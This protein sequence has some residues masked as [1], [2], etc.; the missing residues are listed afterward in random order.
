MDLFT[1]LDRYWMSLLD[2]AERCGATP[3]GDTSET[4]SEEVSGQPTRQSISLAD[5][6]ALGRAV[7]AWVQ[8]R[9][10]RD[11]EDAEDPEPAIV[12][13]ERAIARRTNRSRANTR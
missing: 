11:E 7:T 12:E 3:S 13:F 5:R 2:E 6:V 9:A 10:K 1:R 4:A 8:V